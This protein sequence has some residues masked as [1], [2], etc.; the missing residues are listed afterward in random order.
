MHR[1]PIEEYIH[2]LGT[3]PVQ[4]LSAEEAKRRLLHDGPNQISPRKKDPELVV[5]FRHLTSFFSLLLL[6]GAILSSVAEYLRP[7]EGSLVIATSL[8]VVI[9]LNG[10]FSYWQGHKAEAIMASF[11]DFFPR[12]AVV[13]RDGIIQHVPAREVVRGDLILLS[14]GD[15]V[16]ADAR[17]TE[18]NGLKVD[19]SSL[20]GESEPQLRSTEATDRLLFQSRNVVFSGTTVMAGSGRGIVFATGA[21]SRIGM[22]ADLVQT[23]SPREIP[24]R[25]EIARFTR[26]I[27]VIAVVMGGIVLAGGLI[28]LKNPFIQT[29]VFA[30]GIIVANVPEGLLTTVTLCLSIAARRMAERKGLVKSLDSVET[31]GCTTVICTDKTGTLTENR[32]SVKR[33][34]LDECIHSDADTDFDPEELAWFLLIAT[35]CNNARTSGTEGFVGDPTET[36][37]LSFCSRFHDIDG[38]RSRHHRLFEEPF[39]AATK[40]MVTVNRFEDGAIVCLKGAPDVAI[41]RCDRI[42]LRGRVEPFQE[43][44]RAA[45]LAAYEEIAR[46][47]ERVLLFAWQPVPLREKWSTGEIPEGGFIFV[48]LAGLL[49]PPRPEVPEAVASLRRAGIRVV[50][51]TGDYQ[52]TARAIGRMTG[53]ATGDD[54]TVITGEMLQQMDDA[55]L[56]WVLG[57]R[58][59][60][61]A[62]TSPD[63]KL[64]IVQAFQRR[65]DVVA[66]TGDGVNDAPALKQADIGVAMGRSGTDVAREAADMVILDDNFATLVPAVREGRTIFDNLRK[67]TRYILTSN[68]PEITPFLAYFLVGVPLPLTILLILAVDLGTDM[69]PAI[70]LGSEQP[71]QDILERPPRSRGEHLVDWNLMRISYLWFGLIESMAGF[72]AW[73]AILTAGGWRRGMELSSESLLYRKSVTAFFVAIIFCQVANAFACRTSRQSIITQGVGSNHWLVAGIG[74]ELLL[75]AVI[76]YGE[77]LQRVFGTA[78]LSPGELLVSLP[79]AGSLLVI[80]EF[81]K[82]VIR[83]RQ[84]KDAGGY[85]SGIVP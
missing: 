66:V 70:A 43:R 32:M 49:D 38:I 9:L 60:I 61:F 73:F 34:F 48:G 82:W 33:L 1:I 85:P 21:R 83:R 65:G 69:L 15:K 16:P 71:E 41:G 64:R 28:L 81:R 74:V 39:S 47:G 77:P 26:L 75:A 13:I 12:S 59:I 24:I 44:D 52:T 30:I 17:L 58:E 78:P 72:V 46:Q 23:V 27:S 68:V 57:Q 51:V 31:L 25:N 20:T 10:A 42:L 8:V 6:G 50:M 37:L 80:E 76:V 40:M 63:Q 67:A 53:I 18:V 56:D 7:G 14:E 11:A 45:Y 79:V 22:T 19:N 5:F 84:K 36:A 29:L 54:V 35:L 55:A 3:D 2:R 62:R 4:G